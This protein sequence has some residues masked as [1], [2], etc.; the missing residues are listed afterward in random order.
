MPYFEKPPL[1]MWLSALTYDRVPGFEAKYRF[2]S[3]LFGVACV[4]LTGLLGGL[5]LSPE[6]GLLAGL[7][8]LTNRQFLLDHGARQGVM[9]AALTL[10]MV[11]VPPLRS[12]AE[13]GPRRTLAPIPKNRRPFPGGGRWLGAGLAAGVACWLKPLA[14]VPMLALPAAHAL[15]TAGPRRRRSL[16]P[17]LLAAA[18]VMAAVALP[19]YSCSGADSGPRS[20]ARSSARTCWRG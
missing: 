9:D 1:Y 16:V 15:L 19:W 20:R 17:P 6:A 8:L 12:R 11:V 2:W 14:G 3:A 18:A 7:L 13:S 10:L 5:L 4:A